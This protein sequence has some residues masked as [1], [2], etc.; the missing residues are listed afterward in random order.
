MLILPRQARDKHR[1]STQKLTVLVGQREGD[2]TVNVFVGTGIDRD[3]F[4][5]TLEATLGGTEDA[6]WGRLAA[7]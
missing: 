7:A 4:V 5:A 6:G 1:E 2:G 3:G